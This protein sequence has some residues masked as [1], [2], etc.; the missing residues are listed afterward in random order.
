MLACAACVGEG[1]TGCVCRYVLMFGVVLLHATS[2][3][4]WRVR[5]C[6]WTGIFGWY[7]IRRYALICGARRCLVFCSLLPS[8]KR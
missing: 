1:A 7:R 3:G 4:A 6:A 2:T 8:R 5:G